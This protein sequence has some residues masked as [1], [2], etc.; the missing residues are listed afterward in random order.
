MCPAD[1]ART[2]PIL[3]SKVV[4]RPRSC[5]WVM[6]RRGLRAVVCGVVSG[7]SRSRSR[8]AP[9]S[10]RTRA[11]WGNG[12]VGGEPGGGRGDRETGTAHGQ[13]EREERRRYPG[14]WM[15]LREVTNRVGATPGVRVSCELG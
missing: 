14:V 4:T 12:V 8:W 11:R 10:R 1:P 15:R 3:R 6:I 2:P 7:R 5:K 13:T 9:V